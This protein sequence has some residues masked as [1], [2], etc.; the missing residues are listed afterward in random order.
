MLLILTKRCSYVQNRS[1]VK[2][3]NERTE[4]KHTTIPQR[5]TH[6]RENSVTKRIFFND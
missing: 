2:K 5:E 4:K 1:F 6:L 3:F